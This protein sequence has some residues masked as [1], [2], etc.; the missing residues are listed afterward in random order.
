MSKQTESEELDAD[1]NSEGDGEEE[2]LE[3]RKKELTNLRDRLREKEADLQAREVRL[4]AER[5]NLEKWSEQL[6]EKSTEINQSHREL[7]RREAEIQKR[8]RE[9]DDGFQAKR[10]EALDD[11][12]KEI[13]KERKKREKQLEHRISEERERRESELD[14]E[15]EQKRKDIEEI[16]AERRNE[17]DR[18]AER[19]EQKEA[20]L[21]E[22]QNSLNEREKKLNKRQQKVSNREAMLQQ[23]RD[24]L[25]EEIRI[26]TTERVEQLERHLEEK[27]SRIEDLEDDR[28]R[29]QRRVQAN[30]E[31][32]SR[33]GERK[34]EEVLKENRK[35]E[36][37]IQKLREELAERPT[38]KD[39]A[40]L[41]ELQQEKEIWKEKRRDMQEELTHVK[42]KLSNQGKVQAEVEQQR[43]L[44]ETQERRV[45]ALKETVN[46]LEDD[47]QR[48]QGLRENPQERATRI[49]AIENPLSKLADRDRDEKFDGG[50]GDEIS[51][52]AWLEEIHEKCRDSGLHFHPRLLRAFHTSMK[53][54]EWSPLAVL[55][56][57]SGTGKSQLPKLYAR[58]G[59]LQFLPLS[60]KPNWDS[61]QSLFGYFNPIDNRFNATELLRAMVQSQKDPDAP[62]YDGGF[63]DRMMIV[64]LDEMNLA[65][66]ELYFSDLLSK[67]EERR[68]SDGSVSKLIS[69]G[70]GEEAY[71]LSLGDNVLWTGTMNEDATTKALSDKVLDRSNVLSFPRPTELRRRS[72][73][74]LAN[75]RPLIPKK[76]WKGWVES[77][78]RFDE[79][80]IRDFKD[81]VQD[82]NECLENVGR[83][84]GHRI[85][86]SMEHYMANYPEV[87]AAVSDDEKREAMQT[88]FEDQIVQ[89]VMP[90][91][92]GIETRGQAKADCLEPIADI[93]E[94][95]KLG[96]NLSEDFHLARSI[97][98]GTFVWNSAKYLG[99]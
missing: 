95:Q 23:D 41:K 81:A 36:E 97:G 67:L 93:L 28:Q 92:R 29:L 5:S 13:E 69:L 94:R 21:D 43:N 70:A 40:R 39:K 47:I 85:W 33:F 80:E 50:S 91:L 18:I 55:T 98:H 59:G 86:Q 35:L 22:K 65:H 51:E 10:A 1:L 99:E 32:R 4:E 68:G 84:V 31:W 74:H 96:L 2:L 34:P 25:E 79:D 83:A 20:R 87:I 30:E 57:V 58:F 75:P 9:A 76:K 46:L 52:M 44:K 89:R 38:L 71:E 6:K 61:P 53:T 77:K 56:G 64:L 15:L 45:E 17:L 66:V 73:A 37:E 90:K 12:R 42:A 11:L 14:K 63:S 48:L 78:S 8:E 60:V 24:S 88:A 7:D 54:A 49:G 3:E 27:E 72:E 62:D 16:L 26:R 19:I 82:I